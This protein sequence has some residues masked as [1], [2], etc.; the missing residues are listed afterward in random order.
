MKLTSSVNE[1]NEYDYGYW[2]ND[3]NYDGELIFSSRLFQMLTPTTIKVLLPIV[4]RLAEGTSS[5]AEVSLQR[6]GLSATQMK[7]GLVS[8]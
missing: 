8:L 6:V 2:P 4:A 3:D 1:K 7:L 5:T